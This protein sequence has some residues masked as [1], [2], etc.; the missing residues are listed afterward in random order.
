VVTLILCALA[1]TCGVSVLRSQSALD[2]L[3]DAAANRHP[4]DARVYGVAFADAAAMADLRSPV[5]R[6]GGNGTSRYNWQA[7]GSNHAADWYF[8]SIADGSAVA[9][10]SA[11]SFIAQAR[12]NGAEPLLTIPTIGWVAKL[13]P[14]RTKLASFSIA[15]YGRQTGGDFSYFPDAGN[16]VSAA[17]GQPVAGNDPNDA[18]VPS[19]AAFQQGW[20]QH[21]VTRWG[22]SANGGLRYYILDNEPS[23]AFDPSRCASDRCHDG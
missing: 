14:N 8:E 20:V 15:K 1:V 7:N 18:N 12:S 23:L 5:N 11:D 21:L 17:T 22:K 13:G 3:I 16:G 6:W 2:V 10:D 9:G 4:I 19:A